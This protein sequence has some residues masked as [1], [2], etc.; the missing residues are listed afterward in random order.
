MSVNHILKLG[1][2]K[3][4]RQYTYKRNIEARSRN[5]GYGGKGISIAYSE[6]V[7]VDLVLQR[8]M[9]MPRGLSGSTIFSHF[10]S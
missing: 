10:V 1:K 6:R 4:D 5:H 7:S 8:G 2:L 3:E 9:R